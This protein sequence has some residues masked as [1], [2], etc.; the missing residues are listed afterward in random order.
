MSTLNTFLYLLSVSIYRRAAMSTTA[1]LKTAQLVS[2][3]YSNA[4]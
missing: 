3:N 2:E 1:Q 4:Q